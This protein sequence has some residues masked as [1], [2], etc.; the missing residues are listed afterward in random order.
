MHACMGDVIVTVS[1]GFLIQGPPSLNSQHT[2]LQCTRRWGL[3]K[4][5]MSDKRKVE[6]F[7]FLAMELTYGWSD[8][9]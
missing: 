4:G 1:Y 6:F 8:L 5:P 9:I 7:F 3:D 2:E